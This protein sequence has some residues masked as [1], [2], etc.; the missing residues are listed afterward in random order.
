VFEKAMQILLLGVTDGA[1]KGL[2]NAHSLFM[3]CSHVA[4]TNISIMLEDEHSIHQSY[5]DG[6]VVLPLRRPVV[7]YI[8]AP[9]A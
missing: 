5:F 3:T 9:T 6:V 2:A 7:P 4:P 8:S 1:P